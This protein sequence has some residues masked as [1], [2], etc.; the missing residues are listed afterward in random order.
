M[1]HLGTRKTPDFQ[2]KI[3]ETEEIKRIFRRS[4]ES[5]NEKKNGCDKS[6]AIFRYDWMPKEFKGSKISKEKD[7]DFG[8][9]RKMR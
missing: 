9:L 2:Q 5:E 4:L 6:N 3:W 8:N 1:E 7:N